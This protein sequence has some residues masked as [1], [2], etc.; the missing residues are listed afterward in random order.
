MAIRVLHVLNHSAPNLD[1][2]CIRSSEIVQNQRKIGIDVFV[3]TSPRHET[4]NFLEREAIDGIE[5]FR[6]PKVSSN[7]PVYR[8]FEE[9]SDFSRRIIEV[10]I[11]TKPDLIHAHSP[12]TCGLAAKWAA[13]KLGLPFVYEV[14]GIWEDAAVDQ[15]RIRKSSVKY[16]VS[17]ALETYVLRSA[18][19]VAC[20]CDGLAKESGSRISKGKRPVSVHPN[21]VDL[22]T[23]RQLSPNRE[24]ISKHKLE[25]K[26]VVGYVGSLSS[27]EGV[28]LLIE[29]FRGVVSERPETHLMIVGGGER[30]AEIRAQ[31]SSSPV[32]SSIN[33]VGR[34]PHREVNDYYSIIDLLV[35]P[36]T[37]SRNTELCT[38]LKP[39][40]AMAMN[41]PILVSSVG[42]LMELVSYDSRF[43]FDADSTSSLQQAILRLLADPTA[44]AQLGGDGR[45]IV[46]QNRQWKELVYRYQ[47]VYEELLNNS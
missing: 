24:L 18:D 8:E 40:E 14:R 27:W 32:S 19:R 34:V 23:F 10:A 5:Y 41:K 46:E 1:G 7:L 47:H 44:L 12:A 38:P 28:P 11:E 45:K 9:A 2:Y 35:Y 43:S 13:K 3:V 39:L 15:G 21:A 33:F 17:R 30:E 26:R 42:G 22:E 37:S 16:A 4:S 31:I 29:A 25:G 36:R 20:I 6:T